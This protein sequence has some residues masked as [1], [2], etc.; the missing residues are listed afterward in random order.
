MKIERYQRPETSFLSVD[1]DLEILYSEM[2]KSE[3]LKKLLFYTHKD[4]LG[5]KNLDSGEKWE[6]VLYRTV[7]ST[8]E[9]GN[10]SGR[11]DVSSRSRI[12]WFYPKNEE[13][14]L[15]KKK[16]GWKEMSQSASL[17]TR[18]IKPIP[19]IAIDR[20]VLNYVL[21][22]FP[23]IVENQENPEFRDKIIALDI[24]CH[25][26]QW[27]CKDFAM[28][29]YRIAAELDLL[30]NKKRLS[31]IGK[32]HFLTCRQFALNSEFGGVT[33]LYA[34]VNGEDDG[35]RNPTKSAEVP[36]VDGGMGKYDKYFDDVEE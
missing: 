3:R 11:G 19:R 7:E 6:K 28:R 27:A 30:F 18:N 29:P 21:I 4:P 9:F 5:D 26:D 33:L 23:Q 8:P 25:F 1:R 32:L 14:Y 13:E 35:V 17:F 24:V 36:V 10:G 15:K 16:D 20:E 31:G 2:A 34:A 12:D 22:N